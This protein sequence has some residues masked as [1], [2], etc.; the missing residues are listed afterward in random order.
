ML[1]AVTLSAPYIN[2]CTFGNLRRVR[3][4]LHYEVVGTRGAI[5][6]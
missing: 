2:T 3:L 1:L 5:R 6:C 4:L